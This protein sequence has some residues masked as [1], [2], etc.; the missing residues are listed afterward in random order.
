MIRIFSRVAAVAVI[1]SLSLL[2]ASPAQATPLGGTQW[3]SAVPVHWADAAM[4]WL[5]SFF[6]GDAQAPA[7]RSTEKSDSVDLDDSDTVTPQTGSCIDP[8]GNPCT[9]DPEP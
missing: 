5:S 7:Y 6:S 4:S 1:L 3:T 8:Q 9:V 2:V